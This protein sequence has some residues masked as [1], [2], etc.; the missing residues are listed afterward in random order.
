MREQFAR[1]GVSIEQLPEPAPA[2]DE[3]EIW[4]VHWV[5]FSVFRACATQWRVAGLHTVLLWLGLDYQG[6]DVVMRRLLPDD[7]DA[8]SVFSALLAMEA[9]ALPILNEGAA[10]GAS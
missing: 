7:A 8:A 2:E 10:E 1:L 3:I 6:V 5:A 4:D 9:E